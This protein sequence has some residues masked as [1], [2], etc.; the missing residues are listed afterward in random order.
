MENLL[1]KI[2]LCSFALIITLS[3][4]V[5]AQQINLNG[6]F[7]ET[8]PGAKLDK[9][10]AGWTLIVGGAA[11]ATFAIEDT[12][13]H[14]GNRA[15]LV[16]VTGVDVNPWDIQAVNEPFKVKPHTTYTYSIWV[17]ADV[18]GPIV[19]FTVGDFSYNEWGKASQVAMTTK[20]RQIS[21]DFTTP[22]NAP[23]S[24]RAPIHFAEPSNAAIGTVNYYIDNLKIVPKTT[25]VKE[26]Q[27]PNSLDLG[28][29]YPNP[30]NPETT[31]EFSIPERS[32]A[33]IV[34]INTLGQVVKE[35]TNGSYAAGRHQIKLNASDLSSGVYFYKLEA[36]N[37]VS[38]KKLVL[39]K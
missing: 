29:N 20:W 3:T 30:F 19:D 38:V 14:S 21:F 35:I 11:R 6:D 1:T 4:P 25:D 31:I 39:L 34:L 8:S 13:F 24:G 27:I 33:R 10:I 5:F 23:D 18:Y 7:E 32:N 2:F 22:V 12:A 9:D 28:Q 15:L 26:E 16:K 36:G 37:F 17:K